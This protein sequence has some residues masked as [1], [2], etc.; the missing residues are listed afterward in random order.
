MPHGSIG[1]G[2]TEPQAQCLHSYREESDLPQ[3]QQLL[4]IVLAQFHD[5]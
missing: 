2:Q 1:H 4:C 5:V 3:Q